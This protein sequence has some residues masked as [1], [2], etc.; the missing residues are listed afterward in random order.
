M[1]SR[2]NLDAY[3]KN[4]LRAELSVAD[5]YTITKMLYQGAFERLAQAK[6]A[7]EHGDM[8]G[9]AAKLSSA[10]T[11]IKSLKNTLDFK[12]NPVL[13]QRL[14]DLYTYMLDRI[15]DASIEASSAPLDAALRVLLP[16]KDAWDSIPLSE[17]QK[18]AAQRR[19]EEAASTGPAMVNSLASGQ[20]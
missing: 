3:R 17:Q 2:K 12:R 1:F 15:A 11:I 19:S 10:T 9:K 16:I 20:V 6:G 5:P 4:S 8:E 13:A 18:A 7:I 14:F